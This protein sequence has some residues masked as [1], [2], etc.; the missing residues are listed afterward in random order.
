M[1]K[2]QIPVKTSLSVLLIMSFV[3]V[4]IVYIPA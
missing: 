2:M 1:R 4:F 3:F